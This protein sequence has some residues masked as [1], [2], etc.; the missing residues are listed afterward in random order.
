MTIHATI[1]PRTR[2]PVDGLLGVVDLLLRDRSAFRS[3]LEDAPDRAAVAKALLLTVIAGCAIF[4]ASMGTY[5]GGLQIL[6]AAV[7]LPLAV[8]L[9]A[10]LTAPALTG[11]LRAARGAS[12]FLDDLL[13][14]LSSLALTSAVLAALA[15]VVFLAVL[16]RVHYHELILA[17]VASCVAAG[18]LGIAFFMRGLGARGGAGLF[19]TTP[20]VL[21]VVALVGSQMAW[22][23]RPFVL[24]PRTKE[25]PFVRAI[26][27]G[28]YDSVSRTASS[29]RGVYLR[30]EAPV[31]EDVDAHR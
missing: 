13:L 18:L 24:R 3:H 12:S 2:A 27:G 15:P 28:F 4:G 29:A 22:T 31:P 21:A 6:Y 8:L 20:L 19:A 25:I 14:V 5:R 10:G 26:E 7:K 30:E 1:A 16:A 9:T 17:I 11:A 23:L